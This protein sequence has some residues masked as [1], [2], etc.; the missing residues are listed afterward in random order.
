MRRDQNGITFIELIIAIAISAIIMIAAT[1]FLG[2]AH[3]NYNNASAQ[4]DLQSESQ[5]LMEQ[6]GMWVMEG[7]RVEALDASASGA[8]EGIVIYQIPRTPSV[9]NPD[10]AAAPD[11]VTKRVIW[12]SAS[13]KKLYTKTTTVTDLTADTTVITA[14]TDERQQNLLGEYVTDFTGSV[15]E[16]SKA[17]VTIS[18]KMEYLKQS[19]EIKNVFK[20]RN[21]IR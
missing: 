10:G 8:K 12:L 6:I 21:I 20:V 14:A 1:M 9:E 3:K 19:Y 7:N 11:P 4:I 17:S 16:D 13:G 15:D 18:L 2:A 5:I